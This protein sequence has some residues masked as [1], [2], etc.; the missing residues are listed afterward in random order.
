VDPLFH[1]NTGFSAALSSDRPANFLQTSGPSSLG[2]SNS[3]PPGTLMGNQRSLFSILAWIVL[4][5]KIK[6]LW[7]LCSVKHI[8]KGHAV[9][10]QPQAPILLLQEQPS[11]DM[12]NFPLNQSVS[13]YH[14]KSP[15]KQ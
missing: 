2:R 13:G 8:R 1:Y 6:D 7:S 14:P 5:Q 9:G 12:H 3:L 4:V 10:I 15:E 11:A